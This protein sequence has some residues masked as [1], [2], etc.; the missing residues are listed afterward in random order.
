MVIVSSNGR[1]RSDR[2]NIA[3]KV[4]KPKLFGKQAHTKP[5][6]IIGLRDGFHLKEDEG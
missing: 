3:R 2:F 5:V 6:K 4:D 1:L